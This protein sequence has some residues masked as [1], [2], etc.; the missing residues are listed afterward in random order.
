MSF[1]IKVWRWLCIP[2]A[3]PIPRAV[4]QHGSVVYPEPQNFDRADARWRGSD[5]S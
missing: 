5:D 3:V 2:S 4:A 1:F